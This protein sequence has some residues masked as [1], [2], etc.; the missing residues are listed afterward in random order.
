MY[1]HVHV[2]IHAH[3]HVL[4][5]VAMPV[6]YSL[7]LAYANAFLHVL[8]IHLLDITKQ[9]CCIEWFVS[10]LYNYSTCTYTLDK[11]LLEGFQARITGAYEPS[12]RQQG[13]SNY[14]KQCLISKAFSTFHIST[15]PC[16]EEYTL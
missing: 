2:S 6:E 12:K 9:R 4:A 5:V 10:G 14:V 7:R 11:A 16:M 3:V 1:I 13:T 15:F 8:Y